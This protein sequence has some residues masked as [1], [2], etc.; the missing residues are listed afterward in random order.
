MELTT[1]IGLVVAFG[2]LLVGYVLEHGSI[3]AL[4]LLS[5]AVIVFGGTIGA[6]LTSFQF[7]QIKKVPALFLSTFR[8]TA[9]EE[10]V[11]VSATLEEMAQLV[12]VNGFLSLEGYLQQ[13]EELDP[14]L[15]RG[16]LLMMDGADSQRIEESMEADIA[17]IEQT[18]HSEISVFEAMGGYSPTMGVAGTVM[19]LVQTLSHMASPEELAGAIASAFIATL[20]GIAFANLL[21]LPIASKLKMN[22]KTRSICYELQVKGVVSI[23]KGFNVRAIK[24]MIVPY[25][26]AVGAQTDSGGE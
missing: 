3:P 18:K 1:L 11:K 13:H 12:K 10:I 5:P 20:Y 26:E 23:Q 22:L 4:F 19:G 15:K 8:S 9:A 24:E 17:I 7:R 21:Y 2:G 6:T 16:V 14:I 25:L